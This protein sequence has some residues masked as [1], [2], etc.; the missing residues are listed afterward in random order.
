MQC[1]AAGEAPCQFRQAAAAA[2]DAARQRQVLTDGDANGGG[3]RK[4]E[5]HDGCPRRGKPRV[6]RRAADGK[7]L[8]QLQGGGADAG[9]SGSE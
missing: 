1:G 3:D 8:K 4:G 9:G 2:A 5:P 6:H 7:A